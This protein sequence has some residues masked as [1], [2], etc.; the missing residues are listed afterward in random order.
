MRTTGRCLCGEIHYAF[1]GAPLWVGHCHCESCRRQTSSALAT[2]VGVATASLVFTA[3]K[4]A[5]YHSSPG[6]D[7]SFCPCCGAPIAYANAAE[8]P[9]ETHLYAGTLDDVDRISPT[10]HVHTAEQ[11]RWLE[12]LDD[13][14]RFAGSGRGTQP[15]GRGPRRL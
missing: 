11:V 4:P 15:D 2:F 1:D 5:L 14:P 3:R 8:F 6:V 13:L 10:F 12:I 7:R 9:G